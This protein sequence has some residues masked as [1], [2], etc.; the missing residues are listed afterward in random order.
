M[1]ALS[2]WAC[3]LGLAPFTNVEIDGNVAVDIVVAAD[4]AA[5]AGTTDSDTRLDSKGGTL[6]IVRPA[7]GATTHVTVTMPALSSLHCSGVAKATVAVTTRQAL[8]VDANGSARVV[9]SGKGVR[10]DVHADGAVQVDA[11]D[12]TV[13][14]ADVT[15]AGAARVQVAAK[16]ALAIRG[17][18]AAT[19]EHRFAPKLN[20]TTTGLV[21]VRALPPQ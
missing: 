3:A 5:S 15:V 21:R 1:L 8:R 18:G 6:S 10:L 11:R 12:F 4:A 20:N 9:V 7:S 2:L 14:G 19:V 13:D 17:S 16:Q